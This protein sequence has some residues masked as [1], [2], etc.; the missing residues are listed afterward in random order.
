MPASGSTFKGWN[1]GS[2]HGHGHLHGHVVGEV[3][4]TANFSDPT[5]PSIAW[6]LPVGNGQTYEVYHQPIHW[7]STPVT[8]SGLPRWSSCATII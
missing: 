3:T 8:T 5:P 2:L 1:G 4:V 7:R 6:T